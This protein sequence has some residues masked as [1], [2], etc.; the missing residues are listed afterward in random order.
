VREYIQFI[1]SFV[2]STDIMTKRFF[3]VIPYDPPL[4][5][6]VKKSSWLPFGGGKA[7]STTAETGFQEN[8]TQLEQRVSVVRQGLNSLGVRLAP[9]GTEEL[10]E[11]YFKLFNPGEN[12]TPNIN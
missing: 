10:V 3:V 2:E 4:F 5:N 9:L 12:D 6:M 1:K 8:R 7:S 11:L